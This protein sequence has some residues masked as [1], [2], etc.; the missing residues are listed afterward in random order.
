MV[1]HLHNYGLKRCIPRV[2]LLV[3]FSSMVLMMLAF[4]TAFILHF[5]VSL[6]IVPSSVIFI[7]TLSVIS[8]VNRKGKKMVRII[9]RETIFGGAI[10]QLPTI[11]N[12]NVALLL[13]R[14]ITKMI[15]REYIYLQ[16][17]AARG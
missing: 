5:S 11:N 16:L 12:K 7:L 6:W 13:E 10:P 4:S 15:A 14:Y 2:I 9:V 1:E 3:A 8:Y 17:L